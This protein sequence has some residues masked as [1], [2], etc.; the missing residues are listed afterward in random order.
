MSAK[1]K[2]TPED[3]VY[4]LSQRGRTPASALAFR[5]GVSKATIVSIWGTADAPTQMLPRKTSALTGLFRHVTSEASPEV[6]GTLP[7]WPDP[8]TSSG[9]SFMENNGCWWAI[10]HDEDGHQR[11]C[12]C[13]QLRPAT[14]ATKSYCPEHAARAVVTQ[15]SYSTG[16]ND[17]RRFMNRQPTHA[18][19]KLYGTPEIATPDVTAEAA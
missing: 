2:L 13:A 4:I 16:P 1:S 3:R 10:G 5:H 9:V 15:K 17:K 6:K 11:F 18:V 14:P 19:A 12:G 7:E 8:L